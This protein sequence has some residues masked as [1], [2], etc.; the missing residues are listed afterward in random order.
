M[1]RF[2]LR[3]PENMARLDAPGTD[4]KYRHGADGLRGGIP[5]VFQVTSPLDP[6]TILLPHALVLHI[7]PKSLDES[8]TKKV[9]RIQTRGGFVE[10]HWW[11]DLTSISASATTG[12]FMNI[13][14]GLASVLRR[15][16]IAYDRFLDLRDL[17][18][19]NGSLYNP[20][21]QIALQGQIMLMYDRGTYL[22]TFRSFDFEETDESPFAFTLSWEFKV[23]ETILKVA[24]EFDGRNL[25]SKPTLQ[26][27]PLPPQPQEEQA[28]A[29]AQTKALNEKLAATAK[30]QAEANAA[31][32]V[33]AGFYA[34]EGQAK[35]KALEADSIFDSFGSDTFEARQK[36]RDL[37]QGIPITGGLK[38]GR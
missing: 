11:E 8:F 10:Q 17:Y 29:T 6:R 20:D 36:A 26:Q 15:E 4:P 32:K 30:Q 22:G 7:N 31:Q 34:P 1:A 18:R 2:S 25:P 9:E 3:N 12:A 5:M 35:K 19:N 16:T 13:R 37:V 27:G 21:G 38:V 28:R 33:K 14:T 24:T 23:E